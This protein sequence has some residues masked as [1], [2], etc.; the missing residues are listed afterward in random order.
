[1]SRIR[2]TKQLAAL[3]GNPS[4]DNG[5]LTG[6]FFL[7]EDGISGLLIP[8]VKDSNG[9]LSTLQGPPGVGLTIVQTTDITNPTELNS[10]T[11]SGDEL[12]LVHD[13]L[14]GTPNHQSTFYLGITS[15]PFA[16]NS[17]FVI[18]DTTLGQFLAVSGR[19]SLNGSDFQGA[20]K[21]EGLANFDGT[22]TTLTLDSTDEIIALDN[23]LF[24]DNQFFNLDNPNDEID[25]LEV[26]KYRITYHIDAIASASATYRQ[27]EIFMEKAPSVGA[28][29]EIPKSRSFGNI[30]SARPMTLTRQVFVDAV[31]NDRLRFVGRS[32]TQATNTDLNNLL[33]NIE[34]VA[35]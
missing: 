10:I 14:G 20:V 17:P 28:F 13:A 22:S 4:T 2:M 24:A 7:E 12:F 18:N 35:R 6:V 16:S 23:T 27:V 21:R 32:D 3:I 8:K 29:V 33:V 1:M 30:R 19:F 31:A 15:R 5:V 9:N 11:I 34:V 25:L 26:A